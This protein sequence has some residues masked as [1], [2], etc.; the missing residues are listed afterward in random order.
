[1][2]WSRSLKHKLLVAR[3][4]SLRDW[5]V[6]A[7]AWWVLLGYS[8]ALHL[9]SYQRLESSLK[10][11]AGNL[12][13]S[14]NSL[15]VAYR[16]ERLVWL[17]SRLHLLS[18]TCLLRAFTLRWMLRRRGIP[19]DLRIGVNRSRIGIHAHAWV[20]VNGQAVGE[21]EDITDRFSILN[22]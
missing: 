8:L 20:D 12:V 3:G 17:A 2:G 13:D 4:L 21:P 10:L 16:L 15:A 14:T 9:V 1:M 11:V 18:I 7:E 5:F 6:L 19:A 22:S